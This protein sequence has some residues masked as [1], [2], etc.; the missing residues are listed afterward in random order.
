MLPNPNQ[1]RFTF[2]RW[3][4]T[5]I[6]LFLWLASYV[7]P[8]AFRKYTHTSISLTGSVNG[9]IRYYRNDRYDSLSKEWSSFFVPRILFVELYQTGDDWG[10]MTTGRSWYWG[11]GPRNGIS[12]FG[13]VIQSG[14]TGGWGP[15]GP[16]MYHRLAIPY[17][18]LA[19]V[20]AI[21]PL[22]IIR[23]TRRYYHRLY[24]GLCPHCGYDLHAH[25]TGDKCPECG[26]P[27]DLH[28]AP[29]PR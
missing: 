6:V 11:S 15:S 2:R 3:W 24:D 19:L 16:I 20:T 29:H 13:F 23:H 10:M 22:L 26:A 5:F 7:T 12:L 17:W 8:L 25:K 21:H 27:V 4:P 28:L 9:A 14:F 18:L 1:S